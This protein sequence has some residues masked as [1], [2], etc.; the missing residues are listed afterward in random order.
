MEFEFEFIGGP[1]HGETRSVIGPFNHFFLAVPASEHWNA[2]LKAS[3]HYELQECPDGE[4][5]FI[6]QPKT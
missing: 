2:P 6:F 5:R 3:A 4:L 1:I